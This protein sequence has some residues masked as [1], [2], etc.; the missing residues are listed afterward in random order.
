MLGVGV[1]YGPVTCRA[2]TRASY[3][4]GLEVRRLLQKL[5]TGGRASNKSP[6]ELQP[7]SLF[8][9]EQSVRAASLIHSC[10]VMKCVDK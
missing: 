8:I 9:I 3:Y 4:G 1:E 6:R 10:I 5:V 7:Q 2:I